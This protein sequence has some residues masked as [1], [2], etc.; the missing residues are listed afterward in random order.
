MQQLR[1]RSAQRK[2]DSPDDSV[3]TAGEGFALKSHTQWLRKVCDDTLPVWLVLDSYGIH[4]IGLMEGYVKEFPIHLRAVI[5]RS[6]FGTV[7]A[8]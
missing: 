5:T 3:F 4:G 2:A 8:V 6:V 7:M 1:G